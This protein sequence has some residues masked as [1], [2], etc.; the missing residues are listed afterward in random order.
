M[1]R[2]ITLYQLHCTCYSKARDGPSRLREVLLLMSTSTYLL[3]RIRAGAH[4]ETCAP[5]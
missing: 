5:V 2:S 1:P 4:R 3:A